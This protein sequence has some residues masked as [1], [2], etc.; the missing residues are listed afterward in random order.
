M[1]SVSDLIKLIE[2]SRYKT[3]NIGET[4][5]RWKDGKDFRDWVA[6]VRLGQPCRSPKKHKGLTGCCD[7]V[8]VMVWGSD[9]SLH[10]PGEDLWMT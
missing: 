3:P 4:V 2:R 6:M 1:S 10:V 8:G 9:G 5:W 7:A